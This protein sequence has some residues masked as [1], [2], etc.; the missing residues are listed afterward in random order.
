[1]RDGLPDGRR[2]HTD[3]LDGLVVELEDLEGAFVAA[4]G[5]PTP[6]VIAC[7]VVWATWRAAM[8]TL[9]NRVTDA[10]M[11]YM[12]IATTQALVDCCDASGVYWAEIRRR[13]VDPARIVLPGTTSAQMAGADWRRL[14]GEVGRQYREVAYR[15]SMG[16]A[17]LAH[18]FTAGWWGMPAYP[19]QV[20]QLL[21][22]GRVTR[23]ESSSSDLRTALLE[24]PTS[25]PVHVW[26][27]IVGGNGLGWLER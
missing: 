4:Y 15:P 23:W 9:H 8:E 6:A 12:N 16:L 26:E 7:G 11:A 3:Y 2:R 24:R 22:T 27:E 21:L 10:E 19:H 1:L 5:A 14:R 25:V 20:D 18:H 17:V 13:L